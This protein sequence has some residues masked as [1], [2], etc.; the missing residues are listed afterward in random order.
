MQKIKDEQKA[1]NEDD[2]LSF[3]YRVRFVGSGYPLTKFVAKIPMCEEEQ[4]YNQKVENYKKEHKEYYDEQRAKICRMLSPRSGFWNHMTDYYDLY[5]NPHWDKCDHI[6]HGEYCKYYEEFLVNGSFI[7]RCYRDR[8]PFYRI[9][10]DKI[11][12]TGSEAVQL[13]EKAFGPE[14]TGLVKHNKFT[15]DK[16]SLLSN[17]SDVEFINAFNALMSY[18]MKFGNS[19]FHI[20]CF[21]DNAVVEERRNEMCSVIG[22]IQEWAKDPNKWTAKKLYDMALQS[23]K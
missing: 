5:V 10:R 7:K 15:K 18:E 17:V 2:D 16:W 23:S 20:D 21:Q 12:H 22:R 6:R 8:C 3:N 14:I 11:T 13:F 1:H 4:I 19:G 9:E